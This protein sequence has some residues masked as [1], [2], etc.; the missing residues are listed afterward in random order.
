MTIDTKPAGVLYGRR[1]GKP[2]AYTNKAGEIIP[3]GAV[4]QPTNAK[5]PARLQM[6]KMWFFRGG[7]P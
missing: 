5:P 4:R 1:S 3:P 2:I 6:P 7:T